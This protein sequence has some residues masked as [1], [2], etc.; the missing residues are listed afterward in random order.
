MS[1]YTPSESQHTRELSMVEYALGSRSTSV[2]CPACNVSLKFSI[3]ISSLSR[4][5]ILKSQAATTSNVH[6]KAAI[7][8]FAFIVEKLLI[9]SA[10]LLKVCLKCINL[11]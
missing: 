11:I 7:R 5:Y 3:L 4:L 9:L 6:F 1:E 2:R 8:G 10:T